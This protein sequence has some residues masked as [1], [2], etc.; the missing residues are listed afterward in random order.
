MFKPLR[1]LL[2]QVVTRGDLT[3]LDARGRPH[4]FG[5]GTG[6]PVVARLKDR[7]T[8]WAL[9]TDPHLALGAAYVEGRLELVEGGAYDLLALLMCNLGLAALPAWAARVDSGRRL[10]RRLLQHNPAW[11]SLRN[12]RHHYDI[13]PRIYDLMLDAD[14]QYSCAYFTPGADLEAAQLAKKRHIA[15]K[16]ALAPG[17]RILDIGSGWGGLGLY[18]AGVGGGEVTGV[19][20]SRE[21]LRI[22]RERSWRAGLAGRVTFEL[23]DYRAVKGPFDRIVSVGMFE[24]VGVNHYRAFFEKV[25]DLLADDGVA[26]IHSIG[27]SDG[28]GFTN[29]FISRYIFPGGYFPALSEVLPAIERSGLIVG[30]VEVLR[31]HYAET[32]KAWRESFLAERERA[33]AIAGEPFARMWELYLAGSEA[34]FRYLGLMVFQIQLAKRIDTLPLTRDYMYETERRLKRTEDSPIEPPRMSGT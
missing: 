27:R 21:Q 16:L 15:A 24:H 9:A 13:D 14:R 26:L 20:L 10:A 32:L 34:S 31:L 25:S 8:E 7:R 4:R 28:P 5:D 19:T 3:F 23:E 1:K 33:V 12:V 22:A 29:P 11:R 17:Q 2:Q 30:D 6:A 18:L